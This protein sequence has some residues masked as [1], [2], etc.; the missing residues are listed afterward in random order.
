MPVPDLPWPTALLR[1]AIGKLRS[2]GSKALT[3]QVQDGAVK[4]ME[5]WLGTIAW[6]DQGEKRKWCRETSPRAL[7]ACALVLA[8]REAGGRP[9]LTAGMAAAAVDEVQG[10][11][12]AVEAA[13]AAMPGGAGS[14]AL[15][16]T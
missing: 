6:D 3:Q 1:N 5:L 8:S 12:A 14:G 4:K 2:E 16:L 13:L 15:L 10:S 7:A 9:L 11:A